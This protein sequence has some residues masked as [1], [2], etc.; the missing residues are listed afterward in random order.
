MLIMATDNFRGTPPPPPTK[1]K[2]SVDERRETRDTG[3]SFQ[4]G[5]TMI[6]NYDSTNS[7]EDH[8]HR[9]G[10]VTSCRAA[11]RI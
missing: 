3:T 6:V 10:P 5:V 11:H 7:A 2:R 4:A 1:K 9:I 8:V